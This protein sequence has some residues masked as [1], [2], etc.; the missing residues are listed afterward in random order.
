[1]D[2]KPLRDALFENDV[3]LQHYARSAKRAVTSEPY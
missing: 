2:M 1:M 3:E